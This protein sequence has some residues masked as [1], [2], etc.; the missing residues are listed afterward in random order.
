MRY[1]EKRKLDERQMRLIKLIFD[2]ED[3]RPLVLMRLQLQTIVQQSKD[4]NN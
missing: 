3:A 4:C 2:E 1:L